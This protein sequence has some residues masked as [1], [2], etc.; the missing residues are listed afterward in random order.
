MAT[1]TK[2]I[3][4]EMVIPIAKR[5]GFSY[6]DDKIPPF[7]DHLAAIQSQ[8]DQMIDPL[9]DDIVLDD[10]QVKAMKVQLDILVA[11]KVADAKGK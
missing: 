2:V 6:P 4:D 8:L 3:K 9:Y 10:V 11:E 1:I 5:L 7:E